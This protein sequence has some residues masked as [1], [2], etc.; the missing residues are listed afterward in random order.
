MHDLFIAYSR[1]NIRSINRLVEDLKAHHVDVWLDTIELEVGDLV[2][3]KIEQ[4]IEDSR[5]FAFA[6]SPAALKSYYARKVEFEQAFTKMIREERES[7]ILPLLVQKVAEELP[8]RLGGRLYLDLTKPKLYSQNVRKLVQKIRLH[9]DTFTGG[10]WYKSLNISPLGQPTGGDQIA[11]VAPTGASYCIYWENGVVDHVDVYLNGTKVNYKEFVY[12]SQGRVIENRMYSP[13]GYGG[14]HNVD[15]V[16]YYS[17][18]PKTGRRSKK[19][20]KNQ[21]APSGR[22]ITYD[23]HGRQIEENIITDTGEPDRTYGYARKVFEYT[24]SNAVIERWFDYDG[25]PIEV[26]DTEKTSAS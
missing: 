21:G 10:R 20:M 22:E 18:D 17:Y 23:D 1:K 26:I 16:W 13:D 24:E 7:F 4:A 25:S 15:D 8:T 12:D 19:F 14:W 2:N 11:Q 9:T 5:Y 3:L 6:I